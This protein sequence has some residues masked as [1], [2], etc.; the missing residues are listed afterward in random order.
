M[1]NQ[2]RRSGGA[3]PPGRP[4]RLLAATVTAVVAGS[5]LVASPLAGSAQAGPERLRSQVDT[6]DG[7]GREIRGATSAAPE[8]S[9][10]PAP[11]PVWP[12]AARSKVTLAGHRAANSPTALRVGR[13]PLKVS[14]TA[15]AASGRELTEVDIE[16]IDRATA[17]ASRRDGVLLR[18]TDATSPSTGATDNQAA[19]VD[20]TVDYDAFRHAYGGSWASR[21]RLW[22]LPQCALSTPAAPSCH[23]TAL[24]SRNDTIAGQVSAEVV[25]SATGAGDLVLLAADAKGSAGD[26]TAT[27]LSPSATWTAGGA[28]GGFSW[29]YPMRTPPA[30]GGPTPNVSLSYSSASVDGRSAATN[31]QPSFIG[32][33]FDYWP[34]YIERRYVSCADDMKGEANNSR[35]TGDLCWRSDNATMTLNGT[36]SEL[37]FQSGKGWHSRSEQGARIEKLTGGTN[38]DNNGEYW[39]VTTT[40][41]VQYYFGRN[42]LPG[43]SSTTNSAWTAPVFGNHP[44]EPCHASTFAGSDCTQVWRWNLDYVVDPHGNTMS[45]WYDRETNRYAQNLTAS[46]DIS[47]VRGGMIRRIDYGTWD[48]GTADRSTTPVAQVLFTPADRCLTSNCG[49]H[50]ETNW[51]DVPWDQECTGSEC[52]GHWSPTFWN[53][54]RLAK[55]TTRIWD[56]TKTTPD[57]QEVDSWTL[58]HRFP[59]TGDGTN[60]GLWL[61]S[62]R[63]TGHVGTTVSLPPITFE[64]TALPNRVLTDTNTTNNWQRITNIVTETG[65]KIQVTYSLPECSKNDLPASP[66]SNTRLCYPVLSDDPA[67]PDGPLLTEW[68]HKYVVRQVS[69]SDV[70]LEGGHQA[71]PKYTAY[72]YGGNPAWHYADDDGL[73][74]PKYKT[75]NQFRGYAEVTTRVGDTSGRRTLAVTR[76]LRGMHGDRSGPSGGTRSVIVDASLGSE[77]V[78]DEDAFAGMVREETVYNGAL[79]KP[80]SR[81]VNVPWQSPPTASRTINGDLVTARFTNTR[82]RYAATALGVDGASG[83]RVTRSTSLFDNVHGTLDWTQD[84]GDVAVS[85]DEQCVSQTYNRNP[86]RN[87][88]GLLKRVTTTALPCGTTPTR[89]D[90]IMSDGRFIYDGAADAETTPT[91]GSITRT[92][93]LHDWTSEAGTTFRTEDHTTYD[94]FGRPATSTDIRSVTTKTSYTPARGGPVTRVS[95]SIQGEFDWTTHEDITP[96]WGMAWKTTDMNSRVAEATYDGLGRTT[97]VWRVGWSREQNSQRPST[98]YTYTYSPDRTEYS[99]VKTETLNVAGNYQATYQIYDGFLRPRQTQSTGIGGGRLVTDII[100]D[101]WGR[102]STAYG[103]HVEPGTA[104]GVLWWEP[105]WS[106]PA[107]A[108]TEYDDADRPIAEVSLSGDGVTNLVEKWR[109]NTSYRGDRVLRTPAPGAVPTTTLIDVDDRTVELRQHTTPAGV[110]GAYDAVKHEYDRKN[111]LVRSTDAAGNQWSYKYDIKGRLIESRDPDSGTSRSTYNE[112]GD[113]QQTTDAQGKV[114]VYTYDKLGRKTAQYD[115]AVNGAK[116]R[117]EWKYDRLFTGVQVRGQ[118]TQSTRYDPPGS[119]NAYTWQAI[120]LNTRYQVTGEQYLIPTKE[121]G[122]AGSWVYSYG[123]ATTDGTPTS[124]TYPGTGGLAGETV[125]TGYHDTTGLPQKLTTNLPNVGSYVTGQQYTVYGEPTVLTRKT[126]GGTYVEDSQVYETD[127]RRLHR[128]IVQPETATGPIAER[129]YTYDPAGNIQ[130]LTDTP[131]AGQAETQCFRYDALR[132]LTSAWTPKNGVNCDTDPAAS[133]LGGPAPYWTD[134]TFD[135]IGNRLTQASHGTAGTTTHTYTVP[136][137][138]PNAV[139]PHAVTSVRTEAP[140][141]APVVRSYTYDAAGATASRPGVASDQSL[142]WDP[143]GRLTSV[144][145][146]GTTLASHVYSVDG[147]RIIRRDATGTILYL[148]GMEIR[149]DTGATQNTATRYYGFAGKSIASRS[150]NGGLTWLFNDHQGTQQISVNASTQAVTTRRQTPYGEPRGQQ[151]AWPNNKGFVGG[152]IDPT[153]LTHVGAREYDPTLGRFISVDP[154]MDQTDPQQWHGYAYA[155]NSPVTFSDPTGLILDVVWDNKATPSEVDWTPNGSSSSGGGPRRGTGAKKSGQPDDGNRT[156][157][158]RDFYNYTVQYFDQCGIRGATGFPMPSKCHI[159]A[160]T[161]EQLDEAWASY[162]CHRLGDCSQSEERARKSRLKFYEWMSWVPGIGAPYS[163]ALAKEAYDNDDYIGAGLEIVGVIPIPIAKGAKAAKNADEVVDLLSGS[164]RAADD[165]VEACLR[166]PNSFSPDTPVLMVDG[167]TKRIKDIKVGDYVRA[168]DPTTGHTVARQVTQL[169]LNDDERLTTLVVVLPGGEK[170]DIDTTWEHPFW[171]DSRQTWIDAALL[172]PGERL[173]TSGPAV[174]RVGAVRNFAGSEPMHNLTVDNIHTYYVL[175]GSTPVLVHNSNCSTLTSAIH[176]D[177]LL[178]RAAQKAGKNQTVQRDLDAMQARLAEGNLNPGIGNGFLTGTDVAYAR[179]INGARLFFR[180]TDSG[181]QIV[182]KSD[183][184]NQ[185]AVI[186]RL[187]SIYGR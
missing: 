122:L 46:A 34:G 58:T 101:R 78:Y 159:T 155:N 100:Y 146:S 68:W 71:P 50:N 184:G 106:V 129:T 102:A 91:R 156:R 29:A 2:V 128:T 30:L 89:G 150:T 108:R 36:G 157:I 85:G 19:T 179:S 104:S 3:R 9:A 27:S 180:N 125:T 18:V 135:A 66:A 79:S 69:E 22:H 109:T 143:E 73:S 169:H 82:V 113:L 15:E 65:A 173:Q 5:L 76:Y 45:Y 163:I 167:T 168:T 62:I 164:S 178:V 53:T 51:P 127:T 92:E 170:V 60:P 123:Y 61:S 64:P 139:R 86:D 98:R 117:A 10:A 41:G 35:K 174:V 120:N 17:P 11:A 38:G 176:D 87:Q 105:E 54:K 33:G 118:L 114:L 107:V 121:T 112:F 145:E 134:W 162:L 172:V 115:D 182:G 99:S 142:T 72:A 90:D 52:D 144:V 116:L 48:R 77:T 28:T 187:Q 136:A 110:N 181:I 59:A 153:G 4:R 130:Q 75:W 97:Q 12:T 186:A 8:N 25:A 147:S 175:A 55:V 111:Q 133:N 88:T 1:S 56:S 6:I 44:G 57:W 96:Y 24:P 151:P 14:Q 7:H 158:R 37:V 171:S 67:K 13:L 138:G 185:P 93:Q 32:E 141:K 81:T 177:S 42:N 103:P 74:N 83:W 23:A 26:F 149:R 154:L 137:S 131:S 160:F 126:A 63:H 70:Q 95:K 49:T 20:L 31:N 21:L 94:D 119:A 165:V 40:D 124:T 166:R 47:Y 43:Q 152:D 140:G 16:V 80:V 84:D 39:R 183:K 132:R 148:P 161:P